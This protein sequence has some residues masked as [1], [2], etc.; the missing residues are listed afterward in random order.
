MKVEEADVKI[1]EANVRAEEADVKVEEAEGHRD[2]AAYERSRTRHSMHAY[3]CVPRRQR[4][5][6]GM[7]LVMVVKFIA[8]L[9]GFPFQA[10]IQATFTCAVRSSAARALSITSCALSNSRLS[11]CWLR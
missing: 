6:V 11:S 10:R 8:D 9:V 7:V 3:Q 2:A 1:E 4:L 5:H